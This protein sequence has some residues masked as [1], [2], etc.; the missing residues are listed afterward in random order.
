MKTHALGLRKALFLLFIFYFQTEIY[1]QDAGSKPAFSVSGQAQLWL[2]WNRITGLAPRV[3]PFS[4]QAQAALVVNMLGIQGPFSAAFSEGNLSY[5]LPAYAFYGFSPRYKWAQL[6]LG[7]RSLS[8][9]P[10]S[11]DGHNFKGLGLELR[12]GKFY[13]GAMLGRLQRASAADAGAIQNLEPRYR[14]MGKGLKLGFDD[15]HNQLAVIV[16]HARDDDASGPATDTSSLLRPQEN[17]VLELQG[18]KQLG[19][20]LALAFDLA[21]SAHT[22]DLSAPLAPDSGLGLQGR[23]LGLWAPRQSTGYGQA[24]RLALN[25]NP[26]FARFSLGIERLGAGYLSLG[27]LAFLNDTENIQLG[28]NAPLLKQAL[29]LAASAG[30]QRNGLKA[31]GAASGVRAIGSLNLSARLSA[32]SAASLSLSNINYTLRQRVSTVPFLV[33]DSIVI[34][35]SNWSAQLTASHLLGQAKTSTVALAASLQGASSLSDTGI[36]SPGQHTF[37]SAVASYAWRPSERPWEASAACV[38]TLADVG[39]SSTRLI[40][41]SAQVQRKLDAAQLSLH[42]ALAYTRVYTRPGQAAPIAE[43]RL[44]AQWAP[45]DKHRFEAQLGFVRNGTASLPGQSTGAFSDLNAQVGY[46]FQF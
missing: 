22:R 7:D 34:V 11:L 1:T 45:A 4:G 28:V 17:L 16:F 20:R 27:R 13:V 42:A 44:G 15:G 36:E 30:V 6:H 35:Q 43:A 21:H 29:N 18:K 40:S 19:Q 39:L 41:T 46:V 32:R 9:S 25:F 26:S 2:R 37:Y 12:P 3:Q 33:V 10:Y 23:I 5:Q 38:A 24:W 8:F 14:R 31:Q